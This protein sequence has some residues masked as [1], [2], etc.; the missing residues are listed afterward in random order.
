M[1]IPV[2]NVMTTNKQI[3]IK[4]TNLLNSYHVLKP[5]EPGGAC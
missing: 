1:I 4:T 5:S 3:N 2:T